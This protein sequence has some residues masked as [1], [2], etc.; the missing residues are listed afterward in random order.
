MADERPDDAQV[1]TQ[2][3]ISTDEAEATDV[4]LSPV[5]DE[6]VEVPETPEAEP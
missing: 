3:A 1:T 6:K 4:E 2:P 5:G